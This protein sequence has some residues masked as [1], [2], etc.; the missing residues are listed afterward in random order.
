MNRI[1]IL[2]MTSVIFIFLSCSFNVQGQEKNE[3]VVIV[4]LS[5]EEFLEKV[6]NYEK[7]AD[8]WKYE[9]D[10]PCIVDFYADWCMPCRRLSPILKEIAEE[11][12]GRI[13]VYKVDIQKNTDIANAF[14]ISSIPILWFIPMEGIPQAAMGLLPKET[15]VKT[16]NTILLE[17]K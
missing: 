13:I 17:N 9:G 16:V 4:H 11:Y 3:E 14:G 7:N 5:K 15:I 1:K 2:L 12:K 10:R 8:T 6:Y